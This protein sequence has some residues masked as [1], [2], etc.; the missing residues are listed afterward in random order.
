MSTPIL[1]RGVPDDMSRLGITIRGMAGK[2][3]A[4]A[5]GEVAIRFLLCRLGVV[6]VRGKRKKEWDANR[7]LGCLGYA[8]LSLRFLTIV[9]QKGAE[10]RIVGAA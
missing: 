7:R 6:C 2:L 10:W 3:P 5:M 4:E 8:V 9:P 1:L